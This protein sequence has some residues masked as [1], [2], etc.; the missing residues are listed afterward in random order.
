VDIEFN[1][2]TESVDRAGPVKPVY[3]EP[4]TPLRDVLLL[5][6]QRKRHS[7]LICQDG[8]LT[9]V[10]T[11]RDALKVMARRVDLSTPVEQVMT[12][13][14]VTVQAGDKLGLAVEKMAT[15]GYR[16]L[17]IVDDAGRPAGLLNVAGVIHYLVQHFPKT[18]YNLPPVPHPVM[19]QREGP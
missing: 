13:Q 15:G 9:G 4:G 2:M 1:L 14:P 18:I 11:E 5:L 10:F 7:A 3:V 17:P 19:Q 8:V 6:R 12:P 16:R